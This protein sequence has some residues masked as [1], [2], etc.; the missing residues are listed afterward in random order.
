MFLDTT[1]FPLVRLCT[2]YNEPDWESQFDALFARAQRFVLFS[3][4]APADEQDAPQGERKQHALWLKRNRPALAQW[5]AGAVIV[6]TS[7]TLAVA[8]RV[9]APA[10]AKAFGFPIRIIENEA[11]VSAEVARLLGQK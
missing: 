9:M 5:C 7:H 2:E 4:G 10:M 1:D 8:S 3:V 11:D 6:H